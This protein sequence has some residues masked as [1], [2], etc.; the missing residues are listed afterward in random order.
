MGW[1]ED[2]RRGYRRGLD[3]GSS[4]AGQHDRA[5]PIED[6]PTDFFDLGANDDVAALLREI[7]DLKAELVLAA[8]ENADLRA[9]LAGAGDDER[10]QAADQRARAQ[11]RELESILAFPG[12]RRALEKT[13]H[14]DVGTGGSTT[15]RTE[16]F[17]TLMAVMKRL[18]IRG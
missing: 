10:Q 2:F 8:E 15:T 14:P 12:V 17:Q 16:I 7:R 9:Q 6:D 5:A 11:M 4:G 3:G 18:D 1:F 13:L